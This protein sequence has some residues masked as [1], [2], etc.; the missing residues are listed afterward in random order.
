MNK[1]VDDWNSS[2][3]NSSSLTPKDSQRYSLKVPQCIVKQHQCSK[4]SLTKCQCLKNYSTIR[5]YKNIY[6]FHITVGA[7]YAVTLSKT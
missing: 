3:G 4:S 1:T 7:K 5:I 2:T 6:K